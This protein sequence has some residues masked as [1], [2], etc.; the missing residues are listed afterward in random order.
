MDK[1]KAFDKH[2]VS[3]SLEHLYSIKGLMSDLEISDEHLNNICFEGDEI[4]SVLEQSEEYSLAE[5]LLVK[6]FC[7]LYDQ[8]ISRLSKLLIELEK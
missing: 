5:K 6:S 2:V 4:L 1:K 8:Y 3:T 7:L